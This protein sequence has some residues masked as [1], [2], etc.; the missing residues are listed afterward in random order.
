[1][2]IR[3]CF[4]KEFE[5]TRQDKIIFEKHFAPK[6]MDLLDKIKA[7]NP[8]VRSVTKKQLKHFYKEFTMK[9]I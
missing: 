1:M 3:V 8:E 5:Y 7:Q 6:K 2:K 4:K 9:K